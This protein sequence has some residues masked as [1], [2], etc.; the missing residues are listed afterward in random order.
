MLPWA[1]S[2]ELLPQNDTSI[3]KRLR[4]LKPVRGGWT[5]QSPYNINPTNRQFQTTGFCAA[6]AYCCGIALRGV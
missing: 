4:S 3:E 5:A 2:L 1:G 6:G